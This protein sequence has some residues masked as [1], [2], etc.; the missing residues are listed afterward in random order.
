[1]LERAGALDDFLADAAHAEDGDRF[2]EQL[3]CR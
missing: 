3:A 2:A 1:M